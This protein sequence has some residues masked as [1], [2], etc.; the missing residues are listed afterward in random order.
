MGMT[1]PHRQAQLMRFLAVGLANT[2][3]GYGVYALAVLAGAPAQVALIVQF[4]LGAL[5]NYALHARLVFAVRGWSRLPAYV[6][7]YVAIY[8][9]NA[10]TL[11]ALTDQGYGPL[12]AQLLILPLTVALSWLLIGRIMRHPERITS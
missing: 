2:A 11:R 8:A 9:A 12:A 6:A 3:F 5:W 4:V 7:G 1:A 10:L